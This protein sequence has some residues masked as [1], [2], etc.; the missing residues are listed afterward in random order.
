MNLNAVLRLLV[1]SSILSI[2][3]AAKADTIVVNYT[4]AFSNNASLILNATPVGG[5]AI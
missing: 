2:A 3:V 1:T 5:G 4:D